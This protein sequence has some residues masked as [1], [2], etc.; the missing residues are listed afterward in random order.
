MNRIRVW[1][2]VVVLSVAALVLLSGADASR[3]EQDRLGRFRNLGKAFYENPTTLPQAVEEFKKALELAPNSA[4]EHVNY[5]LALLRAGRTK[6]GVAELERAQ[7]L[8]PKIP[9]TWF[10]LGIVFKKEG[11]YAP[12]VAQFEGLL[13]LVP[14]EPVSHYSLGVLD[15]TADKRDDAV[16]EFETAERLNSNLAAPHFQLY[17]LY[18][19]AGRAADAARE[20]EI[21][22]KLKALTE[23][24]V[25]P[26]DME[27]SYYAEIYDPIAPRP[28]GEP[29]PPPQFEDR[30]LADG[31]DPATAGLLVLDASG[32]RRPDVLAWS[33]SGAQLYRNGT[34]LVADS[35][36]AGIRNIVS[37][38]AGDYDNDG[39]P[40]L[41]VITAAGAALYHNNKG[42]FEKSPLKLPA[43]NFSK[44]VWIDF[45]HDYD[46]DLILLGENA[47][48]ARNNGEAGFSDDT[49]A[50]PFVKGNAIDAAAIDLIADT[51]GVDLAV[52]YRDRAG[53]LYRDRLLGKYEAEPLDT[54]PAGARGLTVFDV[55][56]DSWTDLAADG[57]LLLNHRGQLEPFAD[58]EAKGPL[59]FADLANRGI[60]DML[61]A[62]GVFRNLG[63]DHFE[64]TPTDIPAAVAAVESDFDGDGR[65]DVALI[66]RD[67]SLHLLRNA[68]GTHNN[69]LLAG[70]NGI[71]N[72]KLAPF[73]KVEIK[74][75][76]SYQKRIYRGVPL[77][78]GVDSYKIA[79]S[80]RITW[81]NGQIQNEAEQPVGKAIEYQEAQRMSGSCPMIFTWDGG[82]FRFITDVLG[83]APLGAA[84]GDGSYFPVDHDE[85]VQIPGEA[86]PAVNGRYEIR[87]TEELREVSYLD[88]VKLI[89]VDH[90]AG[91]E[92]FTNDKFKS[93]PF[94]EFR[95]F[96]VQRRIYPVRARDDE[97]RDV[98]PRLLHRDRTYPD[99]FRR[100][101]LD[102]A[103]LHRLDLDFGKAAP[104]NRAVLI[105]NGWVDWADGST[106]MAA[107]QAKK[108]LVLPYLQVK[109]AAGQWQ[110][111]IEDMGIPAGKPKTIAVDL[112]G[113]FLSASREVRIVTNLCVYWDEIFLS[114]E[115]A[116]PPVRL[117][118]IEAESADLH[119]RGFSTPVIHPQRKQPE[120]FDYAQWLP[121][122]MWNPTQGL[123]TRYG[124]VLPLIGKIDDRMVIMGSGDE[125]RLL[126]PER[127]AGPL[128]A[129]WKRDFLLFVDGWAKDADAN[130]AHGQTVE[131]LPFHAMSQYPY[132]PGEQ[133]PDDPG[134]RQYRAEYNTRPA[135]RLI[136]PLL[137]SALR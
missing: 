67:G 82:K 85:Y 13:R 116:A 6:E 66:A 34:T 127:A 109:D 115:T 39:L 59:T 124:D 20:L 128:P 122:S 114:E 49:A 76:S 101:Y 36:L 94:P 112:T 133:F 86:L 27:W 9:H 72:M 79:D 8:D 3:I 30:K 55:N 120:G 71:K 73:A 130:T 83:V 1:I 26:E 18:R 74:T 65:A 75:G 136:R 50:F 93:P 63:L 88:R 24:A 32:D 47:A 113:K 62:N 131:P 51:S 42:K 129:G 117:T 81:P 7:K 61:A 123:Y 31:F 69:W 25:T 4:R 12:A 22:Q 29:A 77:L 2:G 10:N 90:P 99:G 58:L 43:G 111:V 19:Q 132:P 98:L 5:G 23:G 70:L 14:G 60:A 92:I 137:D 89:A 105:L 118:D 134:H 28:E 37:I 40:D 104:A 54:L 106:F 53:V 95:L 38:A 56:N 87:I 125:L 21:F 78:F 91:V 48:L 84:S 52:S 107:S 11:D 16:R 108:D 103:E 44:A 45:D 68:T 17:N 35:G 80:V 135:L 57:L 96:G 97:G 46:L 64:K 102:V 126:F 121:V 41:C 100:N 119:F 110:T 33:S 15:K